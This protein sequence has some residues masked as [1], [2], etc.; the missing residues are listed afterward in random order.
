M[1]WRSLGPP[2]GMGTAALREDGTGPLFD[3]SKVYG[4]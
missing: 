1:G 4:N 3:P 2:A